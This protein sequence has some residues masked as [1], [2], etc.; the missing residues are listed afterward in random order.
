MMTSKIEEFVNTVHDQQQQIV[1]QRG[2]VGQELVEHMLKLPGMSDIFD[3][4]ESKQLFGQQ[5]A[6]IIVT[7]A[8]RK[9]EVALMPPP[10][11]PVSIPADG[12]GEQPTET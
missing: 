12:N 8:T 2:D 9:A 6:S 5:I 4:D 3:T 1:E 7:A 10:P 11:E